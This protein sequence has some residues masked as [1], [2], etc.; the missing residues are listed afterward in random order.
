MT[1]QPRLGRPLEWKCAE[2]SVQDTLLFLGV[3]PARITSKWIA[4][5]ECEIA[6]EEGKHLLECHI[7]ADG[8]E[9]DEV[10]VSVLQENYHCECT[11]GTASAENLPAS[12]TGLKLTA[13][14]HNVGTNVTWLCAQHKP[15]RNENAVSARAMPSRLGVEWIKM[16]HMWINHRITWCVSIWSPFHSWKNFQF[17]IPIWV[18]F[19][20][21]TCCD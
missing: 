4:S 11:K 2:H 5:I 9:E 15:V 14:N 19:H 18:V 21:W 1:T 6:F 13:I 8:K 20:K 7:F 10:G 16:K 17:L 12:P 3:S